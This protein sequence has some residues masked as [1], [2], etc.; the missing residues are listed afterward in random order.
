MAPAPVL[1]VAG[2]VAPQAA[3]PL[4]AQAAQPC[5]IWYYTLIV[6]Q[7]YPSRMATVK[8]AMGDS[9]TIVSPWVAP[10]T[11]PATRWSGA[12]I[13]G[14]NIE[15]HS[16][17]SIGLFDLDLDG[18]PAE[19]Q[20]ALVV[21]ASIKTIPVDPI[22]VSDWPNGTRVVVARY[23]RTLGDVG[24]VIGQTATTLTVRFDPQIFPVSPPPTDPYSGTAHAPWDPSGPS[25]SRVFK[26]YSYHTYTFTGTFSSYVSDPG[27]PF[28]LYDELGIQVPVSTVGAMTFRDGPFYD[29]ILAPRNEVGRGGRTIPPADVV[30]QTADLVNWGLAV[31]PGRSMDSDTQALEVPVDIGDTGDV[32][33]IE[34]RMHLALIATD[35]GL[36]VGGGTPTRSGLAFAKEVLKKTTDGGSV[37]DCRSQ[38]FTLDQDLRGFNCDR[39]NAAIL[40]TDG[41]SNQYNPQSPCYLCPPVELDPVTGTCPPHLPEESNWADPCLNCASPCTGRW[42]GPG[43]PDGGPYDDGTGVVKCPDNYTL[44]PAG[45]SEEIWDTVSDVFTDVSSNP[46]RLD[47]RTWVIGLSQNVGPCELNY[48][49]YMGRTDAGDPYGR[50]GLT[51]PGNPTEIDPFLPQFTGDTSRYFE[52]VCYD[53]VPLRPSPPGPFAMDPRHYAFFAQNRDEFV[54]ALED[55]VTAIGHGD[56]TTSAP[57]VVG[58]AQTLG[59]VALVASARY[60][61]WKGHLYAYNTA[62]DCSSNT[63]EWTCDLNVPCGGVDAGGLKSNCLWDAGEVLSAG[64]DRDYTTVADNNNGLTRRVYTWNPNLSNQLVEITNSAS[65]IATLNTICPTCNFDEN[66]VDFMLGGDGNEDGLPAVFTPRRWALGALTNS[67]AAV[68][69]PTEIWK[70]GNLRP[71]GDFE[72]MYSGRHSVIWVGSSDGM[73][74]AIDVVDGAELLALAPPTLLDNQRT[75]YET[76]RDFFDPT[77][78]E[79]DSYVT[80]QQRPASRHLYG[81]ANSPRFGDVWGL[82]GAGNWDCDVVDSNGGCYKTLLFI[83]E[84]PGGTGLHALDVTHP[85]GAR[86]VGGLTYPADPHYDAAEPISPLWSVSRDGESG[87]TAVPSL[88]QSWSIPALGGS[89]IAE[90]ELVLGAGWDERVPDTGVTNKLYRVNPVTGV[91]RQAAVD[92]AGQD[93]GA[94]VRNQTFADAVLFGTE[95]PIFRQDNIVDEAIQVDLNGQMWFLDAGSPWSLSRWLDLGAENPMYYPPAVA[96]YP[97]DVDTPT[98]NMYAFS[99]GTYYEK[100][101]NVTGPDVGDSTVAGAFVPRIQFE[102]RELG[103]PHDRACESSPIIVELRDIDLPAPAVGKLGRRTQITA[104]PLI[105]VPTRTADP[106]FALFLAYDPDASCAGIS[107]IIRINADPNTCDYSVDRYRIPGEGAASGFAIAGGKVVVAKS[108]VGDDGRAELHEVPDLN[109]VVGGGATGVRWWM[110]LQ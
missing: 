91:L 82:D 10:A 18:D 100:S 4:L 59:T 108:H 105:L 39:L 107:Y 26:A 58:T 65:S 99:T 1:G 85:F 80:G 78:T 97:A 25:G 56:Y 60:P 55:I 14:P 86:I 43:C 5:R 46:A 15:H 63:D 81:L 23:G 30:G 21:N 67:T 3:M 73:L 71:R 64:A 36:N 50:S 90:W 68:V 96:A 2:V 83:A 57:S 88:G 12:T 72:G 38:T 93:A 11:W 54:Q 98:Y 102:V 41:L 27:P 37:T 16:P 106:P 75:M 19:V 79:T 51:D 20:P 92:V 24:E 87:T 42:G 74:H 48:T 6:D 89:S 103:V 45:R 28:H 69:G 40:I 47:I 53:R 13:T 76:Y 9:V 22:D 8:N 33:E 44:Y 84:G 35:P 70:Q 34:E 94:R 31:Y 110:E 66:V 49:A 101:P 17:Q 29:G 77:D 109:I 32:R 7:L 62:V 61:D 104:P 95:S 52:P